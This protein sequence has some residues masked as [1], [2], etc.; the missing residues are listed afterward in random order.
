M[1]MKLGAY[2]LVH[3]EEEF[4]AY[5][6]ASIHK[7]VDAIV[8]VDNGGGDRSEK[9][10]RQFPKVREVI[11]MPGGFGAVNERELRNAG[12]EACRKLG[13]DWILRWDA[14]E[15]CYEG[16]EDKI[17][18]ATK[19]DRFGAWFFTCHRFVGNR[20]YVQD[21]RLGDE[22]VGDDPNY[23]I[24]V[25]GWER[26]VRHGK[27]VLFRMHPGLEYVENPH[28]IG[29]HSS[30]YE[31][32][33]PRDYGYLE[34]ISYCHYEWCKSNSELYERALLYYQLVRDPQDFCHSK[35]FLDRIDPE[36]TLTEQRLRPFD[37]DHPEIM[38]LFKPK[39]ETRLTLDRDENHRL[40]IKKR[41]CVRNVRMWRLPN[42]KRLL[43]MVGEGQYGKEER[44]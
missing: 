21:L 20:N 43:R 9:L 2:M 14:D 40:F 6:L 12:I 36:N 37:R 28:Y 16:Q 29:L 18:E 41:E 42:V 44:L 15:V 7:L 11:H 39:Y 32:A 35:E 19:D 24:S 8:I 5:S 4:V 23:L 3:N 17:R 13:A 38:R 26:Q 10:Y 22:A 33:Q 31:S 27:I 30:E 34:G 1:K 25:Q